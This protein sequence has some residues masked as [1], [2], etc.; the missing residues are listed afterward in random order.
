MIAEDVKWIHVELSSKCNAWCPACARNNNGYGLSPWIVEQDLAIERYVEILN[1]LPNLEV[2]HLCGNLGDP[3]I[4]TNILDAIKYA[5]NRKLKIQIHTNGSLRSATWWKSLGELL[6][7]HPHDVW[8]GL[9][10]IS[11]VHEIYRQG[12]DYNKIINN[13]TAFINAGGFATWQFIPFAHNEHQ[14]KD[15]LKTSQQL[16]FKKFKLIKSYRNVKTS[17]H[18]KTGEEFDLLPPVE[19]QS[20]IRIPAKLKEVKVNDCMHVSRPSIYLS[21]N[22][23]LSW[24]CYYAHLTTFDSLEELFSATADLTHINCIKSCGTI[25]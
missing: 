5:I 2:V 18:Y 7:D 21:A 8:F 24:C 10:G 17:R 1:L 22:G 23:L 20:M 15:C 13:A 19:F 16:G 12:T 3:I 9:D 14:L 6:K 11:S 25:S 4:A